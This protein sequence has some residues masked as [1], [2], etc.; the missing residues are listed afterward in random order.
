MNNRGCW[1]PQQI[2]A[3]IF[4][5]ALFIIGYILAVK[6][7]WNW[8]VPDLFSGPEITLFQTI[9]LILLTKLLFI[10]SGSGG[11]KSKKNKKYSNWK[12]RF[13]EKCKESTHSNQ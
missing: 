3:G 10:G 4:F 9:G 8:L 6:T 5:G 13:E 11:F 7:L 12:E 1:R 2:V